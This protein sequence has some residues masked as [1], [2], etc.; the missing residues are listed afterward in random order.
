M[1]RRIAVLAALLVLL[2]AGASAAV[3]PSSIAV[4]DARFTDTVEERVNV[5]EY[6]TENVTTDNGTVVENTTV[7]GWHYEPGAR[8]YA[9]GVRGLD[10]ERTIDGD[11]NVSA[12][13][14]ANN[15]TSFLVDYVG[16]RLFNSCDENKYVE[17]YNDNWYYDGGDVKNTSQLDTLVSSYTNTPYEVVAGELKDA[18]VD[19]DVSTGAARVWAVFE[20][21]GGIKIGKSSLVL[22]VDDQQNWNTGTFNSTSSDRADNSGILGIGYLNGTNIANKVTAQLRLDKS[23]GDEIDYSG[24]N[25]NIDILNNPTRGVNGIWS[26]NAFNWDSDGERVVIENPGDLTYANNFTILTWARWAGSGGSRLFEKKESGQP[27]Y[28]AFLDGDDSSL[29]FRVTIG[30]SNIDCDFNNAADT[31]WSLYGFAYNGTHQ[32]LYKNG[33]I[34]KTCDDGL[35]GTQTID[36]DDGNLSVGDRP[37]ENTAWRGEIDEFF[38]INDTL[39]EKEISEFYRWGKNDD[40]FEGDY[41]ASE[42]S[43]PADDSPSELEVNQSNIDSSGNETW[44]KVAT[45]NGEST[46]VDLNTS[47]GVFNYSIGTAFSSTGGSVW[48]NINMTANTPVLTPTLESLKIYSTPPNTSRPFVFDSVTAKKAQDQTPEKVLRWGSY[49]ILAAVAFVALVFGLVRSV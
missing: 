26:S 44:V 47:E 30:G 23:S 37:E 38:A 17:K 4:P 31:S 15:L 16:C 45:D 24:N 11:L 25:H 1:M 35:T 34:K 7:A 10:A 20:S 49:L 13:L 14:Y 36:S 29:T 40:V 21:E 28:V 6:E 27:K 41:N 39:N 3:S 19:V 2:S 8:T 9:F 33:E 18:S 22:S 5:T 46:V 32:I 42:Q 48:S 43:V 12:E